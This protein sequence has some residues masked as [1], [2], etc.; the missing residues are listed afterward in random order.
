MRPAKL[1]KTLLDHRRIAQYPA[2][3]CAMIDLEAALCEH[4]FQI[5]IAQRIAQIPGNRLYNQPCREMPAFEIILRLALQLLGNGIQNHG[6][7]RNFRSDKF[8][9][10]GQHTVKPENCAMSQPPVVRHFK[11]MG[12][13]AARDRPSSGRCLIAVAAN[14]NDEA[15]KNPPK[16]VSHYH[17]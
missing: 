5:S 2:V 14:P 10:Y 1:A 4:L 6:S 16:R 11:W 12:S 13:L 9:A 7:L 8:H 3:D 15:K 17:V